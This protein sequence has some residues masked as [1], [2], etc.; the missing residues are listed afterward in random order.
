MFS[1]WLIC[2]IMAWSVRQ[3]DLAAG[4]WMYSLVMLFNLWLSLYFSLNTMLSC[5]IPK[6]K[7]LA[8]EDF[9]ISTF[10]P[11]LKNSSFDFSFRPRTPL[12]HENMVYYNL[13]RHQLYEQ[14]VLT[15]SEYIINVD[16]C[17]CLAEPYQ[18]GEYIFVFYN[19]WFSM[20]ISGWLSS[21]FL[22][23]F[24]M[25]L[26]TVMWAWAVICLQKPAIKTPV[27]NFA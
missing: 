12:G 27:L 17:M 5:S 21:P 19:L 26:K 2:Q 4:T 9:D 22:V 16:V 20:N 6:F 18:V 3:L 14:I 11:L 15:A 25:A 23:V 24:S 13:K 1:R 7:S 10:L 8:P